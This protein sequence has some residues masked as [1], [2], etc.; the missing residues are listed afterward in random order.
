MVFTLPAEIAA[1]AFQNKTVVYGIL[2]KSAAETLRIIAA[3]P[4]HLGAGIGL[5]A[6]LHSWGQT[7]SYHPHLHCIVPGGGPSPDG[8][9][10]IACR[11]NFF[12][13]VR[14]L[15][16][17]YRRLFLQALRAA[18]EAG[19]LHFFGDIAGLA[20][21]QAFARHLIAADRRDWVVYAKP[22]FGGP[23]Q[24]LAYLSRYTHR[25]AIANSRLVSTEGGKVTFRWRDYR[26][27]RR[28]RHMTLDA[29]E[30]IRRFLLHTLPD[31]V[32]R[33]R[34]Y[35]FLANGQRAARLAACRALLADRASQ[36]A[37]HATPATKPT[38]VP[39]PCPCCGRPMATI[40]VWYH[41]QQP[42]NWPF[43]ND[44]S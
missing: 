40:T 8:T 25:V 27:G 5:V 30:F 13:P 10:W 44:S 7:L 1:I 42:P 14:V 41:G 18:F 39:R 33:I 20:E 2:F 43:W 38:P 19:Q 36:T 32:H 23:E 29:G 37:V 22:P 6:V 34:H 24:V 35:G 12:L 17:L 3:D 9:R 28:P 16:R 21:P 11:P 15:S 31:G 4:R 26:H